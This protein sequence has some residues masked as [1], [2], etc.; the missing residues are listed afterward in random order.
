MI[1]KLVCQDQYK[2]M[3]ENILHNHHITINEAAD[4]I[5]VEMGRLQK[6]VP[7]I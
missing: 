1:V 6:E 4:V 2:L 7:I 3:L 5:L